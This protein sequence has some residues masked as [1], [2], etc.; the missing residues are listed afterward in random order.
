MSLISLDHMTLNRPHWLKGYEY[1]CCISVNQ[2]VCHGF[3]N[4]KK[5]RDGDIANVDVTLI[6]DGWN[7][8][9][10]CMYTFGKPKRAAE[11][12]IQI[13]NNA[14][15]L[16]IEAVRPGARLGDFGHA[17]QTFAQSQRRAVVREFCGYGIGQI[18]HDSPNIL[19]FGRPGT[20]PELRDNMIFSAEP[21]MI[22]GRAEEKML[23]G[24]WTAVTR[25]RLLSAQF[26]NSIG[27]AS[28][29]FEVFTLSPMGLHEPGI[30]PTRMSQ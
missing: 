29:G 5:L 22:L 3:P 23:A 4:E 21:M 14:M 17:F 11:W 24:D 9:S 25:D 1:A 28:D 16:G 26:E 7:G 13:A 6:M 12:L 30:S 18:F 20:G 19:K 10:S 2:V 8:N 15:M 27:V